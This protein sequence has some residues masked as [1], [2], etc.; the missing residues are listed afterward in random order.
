V[1][2]VRYDKELEQYRRLME[3]PSTFKDGFSWTSLIGAVFIALLMVPGA[4]YMQLLAGVGVGPAAQWVTVILFIE[5]ARRAHKRLDKPEIFVLYYMA[6]AIMLASP[7]AITG[8]TKLLFQQFFIQSRAATGMGVA[9]KL[10]HWFAP[11]DPEILGQRN[12]FNPA[13]YPA[14]GLVVFQLLMGRLNS[15]I[16]SYG[17]F[18]I[19][20]DIEKLPFPMAPI[21]AQ[22]VTALAE[23]QSEE[24][25]RGKESEGKQTEGNWR[26]RVFSIGGVLGL[27]FGAVYMALPTLSSALFNQPITILPIPFADWTPKT[28][29]FLPAVATGLS[30]DLA[31]FVLGMV[32]PFF[33]MVGSFVGLIF[34]VVMNVLLYKYNILT[35]WAPG[36]D[37]V[38]TTFK[39]QVDF[40]FSFAIGVA[41][42]VAIM[43]FW[44]IIR[45]TQRRRSRKKKFPNEVLEASGITPPEGRGD[46]KAPWIIGTYILTS[47]S[48][49]LISGFLINW[50]PGVMMVLLFF[51][52]LYTPLISYVTARLEG[53]AGQV[54]E[55]PMIREAAFILSG[56]TGGVAVWFLPLPMA[57]YGRRTVFYRQAE[58]T[59]TSFW[60]IWKTELILIPI[61][62]LASVLFSQFIWSLAEIPSAQYP[63]A[64]RIW[65][66]DAANQ[67]LIYTS[68]L[69]RFS[70]FEQAF[71]WSYLGAGTFFGLLLFTVMSLLRMPVMLI[72]GVVR[73][74]N[75]TLPHVI[76]P[77]F[78]GALIGRFY[79]ERRMG[80][81]WR[82][83]IPVVFA[84]FSCGAGLITVLS[85]GVRF[86]SQSVIKLPF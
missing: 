78:L 23:Q 3:V 40:Y 54:V 45:A 86:L 35:Q 47:A 50:H 62:L 6:G 33:A 37:T 73:G 19:A 55:I 83:Y 49:I 4:I 43:G 20:S 80:L 1:S 66:L 60:S 44:Q 57:N 26:W 59:G 76:I 77:Q 51:A 16:L 21:G 27:S 30:F 5:V 56:Y 38:I 22:G 71:N 52:F 39:N 17:L 15:T 61:V 69:G 63:Y 48:Y 32:L 29:S 18:R 7:L 28:G 2:N 13:W 34:T 84:G 72:Y 46:I 70:K 75:Q 31:Q 12:F 25:A 24:A 68:T 53:M 42:A 58:L 14:I 41:M 64:E 67:S 81:K 74:L 10:P 79:F 82:E 8:P 36:D 65:E 9:E 11:S 85:V